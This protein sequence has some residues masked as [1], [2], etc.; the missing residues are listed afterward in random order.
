MIRQSSKLDIKNTL[1]N[2]AT[3]VLEAKTTPSLQKV[4]VHTLN[5]LTFGR[6]YRTLN[7]SIK[8]NCESSVFIYPASSFHS[9]LQCAHWTAQFLHSGHSLESMCTHTA[10]SG[11]DFRNL[12][13]NCTDPM[14][15]IAVCKISLQTN[16]QINFE[17]PLFARHTTG[18][19]LT[20]WDG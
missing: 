4:L 9:F 8:N 17:A 19:K 3:Y 13:P 7:R 5:V 20:V 15:W 6:T 10:A 16:S 18:A 1:S 14:C 2:L 12:F 11:V